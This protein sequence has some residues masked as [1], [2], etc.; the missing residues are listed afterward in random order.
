MSRVPRTT[1]QSRPLA[2]IPPLKP[3]L[4]AKPPE[5]DQWLHEVK[6]DG[7]RTQLIIDNHTARAFTMN[8]HDWTAQYPT[9][10]AVA[11]RLKCKAAIDGE[12]V[13]QREDGVADFHALRAALSAEPH[14]IVYFAFDLLNLNGTD[15]RKLPLVDRQAKL[16]RL[17]GKRDQKSPLQFSEAVGGSGAEVFKAAEQLGLEGII[18][19]RKASRYESGASQLWLKTKCTEEN[20]FVVVGVEPNPGGLPYALLARQEGGQLVYAGSAFV[21]LPTKARDQFWQRAE[22]L[23]VDRPAVSEIRRRKV[24][25]VKPSIRVRARHLRGETTL[26]HASLIGVLAT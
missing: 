2:F 14:R 10:V 5:G 13:V 6:H 12:A 24:G 11:A 7:Y 21:T 25:F 20:E 22:A 17:L 9:L 8:G 19:K 15:L 18:S 23:K 4:T 16:E 1:D 26:R 3:T